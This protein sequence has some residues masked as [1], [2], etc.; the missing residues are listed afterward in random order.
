[1]PFGNGRPIMLMPCCSQRLSM[2]YL[3]TPRAVLAQVGN[4]SPRTDAKH[5]TTGALARVFQRE[6]QPL[7]AR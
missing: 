2:W 1:M 5:A 7:C 3:D 6:P 4:A